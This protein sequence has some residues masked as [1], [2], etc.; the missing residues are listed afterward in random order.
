MKILTPLFALSL[1]ACANHT[2]DPRYRDAKIT[3]GNEVALFYANVVNGSP[4]GHAVMRSRLVNYAALAK[5][6]DDDQGVRIA[7]R[8]EAAIGE[9]QKLDCSR[10]TDARCVEL[11]DAA[12]PYLT[13]DAL[14]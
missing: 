10:I 5:A 4:S 7:E 2:I 11:R 3:I 6:F 1:I 14:N 13:D 8:L 9:T 12:A